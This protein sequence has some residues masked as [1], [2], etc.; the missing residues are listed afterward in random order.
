M[1]A[2]C[3]SCERPLKSPEPIWYAGTRFAWDIWWIC[4]ECMAGIPDAE[5]HPATTLMEFEVT[6]GPVDAPTNDR[7]WYQWSTAKQLDPRF[8]VRND[9]LAKHVPAGQAFVDRFYPFNDLCHYLPW[10]AE[11]VRSGKVPASGDRMKLLRDLTLLGPALE[12]HVL[13]PGDLRRKSV[14]PYDLELTEEN[15][16]LAEELLA[17]ILKRYPSKQ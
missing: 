16:A 10:L 8:W 4:G 7:G 15:K 1:S 14:L 13:G 11:G 12:R 17:E 9:V 5:R 3:S 2:W 6:F